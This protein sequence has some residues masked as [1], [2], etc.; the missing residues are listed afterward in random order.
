MHQDTRYPISSRDDAVPCRWKYG[1]LS[2]KGVA[3]LSNREWFEQLPFIVL[4]SII[5]GVMGAL[6]NIVHKHMFRV[7]QRCLL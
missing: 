3:E 2:F 5:A 6:F 7:S 1:V 4:I